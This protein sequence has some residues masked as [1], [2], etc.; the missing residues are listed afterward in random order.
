[1]IVA[2]TAPTGNV[3][4][5]VTSYLLNMKGIQV[6]LLTRNAE[7]VARCRELGALV[8]E[9][10]LE[11]GEFVSRATATADALF[12]VTP[13]PLATDDLRGFQNLLGENAAQAVVTNRIRRVVNLSSIGAH[14]GHGTGPIDGLHDVEQHLNEAAEESGSRTTHLRPAFYMENYLQFAKPILENGVVPLPVSG[15]CEIPMIATSDVAVEAVRQLTFA[16]NGAKTPARQLLGPRDLRLEEAARTLGEA[17]EKP[18]KH[19]RVDPESTREAFVSLGASDEVAARMVQMYKG[20]EEGHLRP[21][22]PRTESSSTPTEFRVFCETE[23]VPQ[24]RRMQRA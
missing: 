16:E 21:E 10:D 2:V 7:K 3:G 22:Y 17:L 11:D 23:L 6:T 19:V 24:I 1:M 8:S 5:K 14:L 18:V 20:V 9:G 13:T 12:W 15:D 4:G